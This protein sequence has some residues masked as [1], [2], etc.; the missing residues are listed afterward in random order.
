M[1]FNKKI[2]PSDLILALFLKEHGSDRF[3]LNYIQRIDAMIGDPNGFD[4]IDAFKT[5]YNVKNEDDT[6]F[7]ELD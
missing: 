2:I 3:Y 7:Y 5:K 6:L 4:F 1:S